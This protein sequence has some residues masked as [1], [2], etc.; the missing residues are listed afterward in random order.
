MRAVARIEQPSTRAETT[1]ARS[2][3]LRTFAV[4]SIMLERRRKVKARGKG[5]I[6]NIDA[7]GH[8]SLGCRKTMAGHVMDHGMAGKVW[9]PEARP[10]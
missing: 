9:E 5:I 7:M 10:S 2:A 4:L 6:L 8:Q 3:L 1:A